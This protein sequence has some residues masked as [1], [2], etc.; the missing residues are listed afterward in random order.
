MM[1]ISP[2]TLQCGSNR[3]R[4][5]F[6][7]NRFDADR[8]RLDRFYTSVSLTRI[9]PHCDNSSTSARDDKISTPIGIVWESCSTVGLSFV[10][11][12]SF[13]RS[14]RTFSS[15]CLKYDTFYGR[16]LSHMTQPTLPHQSGSIRIES[17]TQGG[18]TWTGLDVEETNPVQCG[19]KPNSNRITLLV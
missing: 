3:I 6:Q 12:F 5:Q 1:Y 7:P 4:I 15:S 17:T 10:C 16:D 13:I 19:L 14:K 11:S 8:T 9:D 18:L 2:S